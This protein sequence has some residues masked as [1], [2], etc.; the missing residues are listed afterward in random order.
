MTKFI[1]SMALLIAGGAAT[2]LSLLHYP[3]AQ[4]VAQRAVRP[5]QLSQPHAF[6]ENNCAACHTAGKGVEAPNCIVCHADNKSL[7][8]REPTVFH[9]TIGECAS[10]HLEHQG[11]VPRATLM[12]HDALARKRRALHYA[13]AKHT[14]AE[15]VAMAERAGGLRS[16]ALRQY[17]KPALIQ[18][19]VEH[20]KFDRALIDLPED[21]T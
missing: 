19:I 18:A 1:L 5:G 10:C 15:L 7:L 3:R 11:R 9:A 13:Y 12:D 8:Q 2:T 4:L 20:F 14:K 6:L 21:L 16:S 17:S